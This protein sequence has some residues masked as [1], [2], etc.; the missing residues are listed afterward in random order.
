[1]SS[2]S[3]THDGQAPVGVVVQPFTVDGM[4]LGASVVILWAASQG[5]RRPLRPIAVLVVG[6]GATIA[7]NLAADLSDV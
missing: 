3:P 2:S 6:I 4:I 7:A 1:M 5:I